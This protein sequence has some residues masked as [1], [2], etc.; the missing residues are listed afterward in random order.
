MVNI[1]IERS[2]CGFVAR[3]PNGIAAGFK[4]L[5]IDCCCSY[6]AGLLRPVCK[7]E[8]GLFIVV[9][10]LPLDLRFVCY[11]VCNVAGNPA[12]AVLSYNSTLGKLTVGRNYNLGLFRLFG[13]FT[14]GSCGSILTDEN[15]V[16]HKL[17]ILPSQICSIVPGKAMVTCTFTCIVLT[18][19]GNVEADGVTLY[20]VTCC[21][22]HAKLNHIVI[23]ESL[24]LI[25]VNP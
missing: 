21:E 23:R 10:N 3:T 11:T 9:I 13:S 22:R 18:V 4:V 20:Y 24:N 25:A 5:G 1:C 7:L 8:V 14:I 15:R 2:P 17:R 6:L 19:Y 16:T 12:F